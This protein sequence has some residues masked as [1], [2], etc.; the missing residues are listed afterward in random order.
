MTNHFDGISPIDVVEPGLAKLDHSQLKL[1]SLLR[2]SVVRRDST[3]V[4]QGVCC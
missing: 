1:A 3:M 4:V 2:E